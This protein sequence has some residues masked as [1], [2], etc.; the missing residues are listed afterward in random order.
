MVDASIQVRDGRI[1]EAGYLVDAEATPAAV[2]GQSLVAS[3]KVS[4]HFRSDYDEGHARGLDKHPNRQVRHPHLTTEGGGQII[5]SEITADASAI[6]HE[7]AFD[8]RLSC[9]SSLRGCAEL[10]ELAPSAWEDLMTPST[11]PEERFK[12]PRDYGA[13]STRSLARLARDMDNVLFVEVKKVFPL[14]KIGDSS[15]QDVEFHL[16]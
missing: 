14:E 7:R 4:D 6:E 2:G 12:T 5:L 13:C 10:S 1:M 8:F 16:L 15:L 3:A 9:I 11:E